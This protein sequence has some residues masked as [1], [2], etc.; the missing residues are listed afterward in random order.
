MPLSASAASMLQAFP[1]RFSLSLV[2]LAASPRI[3]RVQ[4]R[5]NVNHSCIRVQDKETVTHISLRL[6]PECRI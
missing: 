2:P 4:Y 6:I 1:R 5:R 3:C